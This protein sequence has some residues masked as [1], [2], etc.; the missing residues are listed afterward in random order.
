[1]A[2][3]KDL[4]VKTENFSKNAANFRVRSFFSVINGFIS[5]IIRSRGRTLTVS[6]K[7]LWIESGRLSAAIGAVAVFSL[8]SRV[9]RVVASGAYFRMEKLIVPRYLGVDS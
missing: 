3:V 1:M 9:F 5:A 2:V 4:L 6:L 8:R 7:S